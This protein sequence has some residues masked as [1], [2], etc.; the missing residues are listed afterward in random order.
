MAA[1]GS[2]ATVLSLAEKLP[3]IVDETAIP[4]EVVE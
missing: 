4:T 1:R 2:A 3:K